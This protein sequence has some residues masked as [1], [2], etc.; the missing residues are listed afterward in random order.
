MPEGS[1][2]F[3]MQISPAKPY[4]LR[5]WLIHSGSI[6]KAV[7]NI[8]LIWHEGFCRAFQWDS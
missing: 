7:Y 1:G 5:R 4:L 6:F 8:S 3:V 2:G